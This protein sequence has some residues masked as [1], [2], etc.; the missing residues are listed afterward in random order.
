M[1]TTHPRIMMRQLRELMA[2]SANASARLEQI[3]DVI[4]R[5]MAAD[6]C[7]IYMVRGDNMLELVATKGLKHEA[8]RRTRL[9]IGEGLVGDIAAHAR[10][11]SLMDAP[12]HPRFAY[13][14]E[15]GEER[16]RS[17]LG[18][19]VLRA[20]QVIGVLVVQNVSK[21]DYAEEEV[22]AL[23][24]TAMVLAEMLAAGQLVEPALADRVFENGV[25][26]RLVGRALA[27]GLAM[28]HVVLHEPKMVVAQTIAE[29]AGLERNRL[30]QAIEA[31]RASVDTML[32]ASGPAHGGESRDV[33]EAYRMFAYDH[34]WLTRLQAAVDQGITAEAA[35]QRVH[36]ETRARMQEVTDPYLRER[37]ADL[38]D[39]AN[40]LYLHLTGDGGGPGVLPE[41]AII[42]ARN[43]GPAELLDYDAD[44]LRAVVL[45]EGSAASH[46][47]VVARAMDIPVLGG[48]EEATDWV[49]SHDLV[50]VD[51]D[52]DQVFLRPRDDV[53]A[54]F[55][56]N[57]TV[58]E[59]Q[60]AKFAAL[61]DRP[62][63]SRDGVR[64]S[65]NVNAGLLVD[66]HHFR[67]TNADGVG[68]Y[69]TEMHFM[70]HASMPS[71][72][73]QSDY[74]GRV[75]DQAGDRPVVFRTLDIGGDKLL[76]YQSRD[77]REENPALGW[78]AV[79]ISLDRPALLKMQLRA[80]LQAAAGRDL[81]VMFPMIAE[82]DEF[83]AARALLE[84]EQARLA[85]FGRPAPTRIDVGT[86]LEVPS[87][88]WQLPDLL[89]E[90]DFL[91]IGSNDLVQFLF[92]SDRTNP[93]VAQRYDPLSPIILSLLRDVVRQCAAADV[94]V[95][96]CGDMA[97][98]PLEAM[99]LLGVGF[100]TISMPSAATGPVKAMIMSLDVAAVTALIEQSIA[101]PSH[102]LRDRLHAFATTNGVTI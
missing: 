72:A 10:P 69:R 20:G 12:S 101:A 34:G 49:E 25:P 41:D 60:R 81:R 2:G 1:S 5:N 13:R 64:I 97:G 6:V 102:S 39:L 8:V 53:I 89:K 22:E 80:L 90:I 78:R 83:R 4:A 75:L 67:D 7:S 100:R 99:A 27:K 92:A 51:A 3:V 43:M 14:P 23:Q 77:R 42:V 35:I 93:R 73:T 50:I 54:A 48:C 70:V 59:Q 76:P 57:L 55:K 16:Y 96:L 32:S 86:M 45:E 38:D 66:M 36:Q 26:K 40:R 62:A 44:R 17:L 74:Y 61:R 15:T 9:E 24:T 84:G 94:P 65:L 91:S 52:N 63:V 56:Q 46:V 95:S 58:R 71:I 21:R 19:P 68:L 11:L 31:L 98:D 30:A 87:L 79:R 18:V 47:A 33:L 37:L 88:L 29:D 85:R 28:G 82:I